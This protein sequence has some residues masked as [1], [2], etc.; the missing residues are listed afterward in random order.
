MQS[1]LEKEVSGF[2]FH[3]TLEQNTSGPFEIFHGKG[4]QIYLRTAT[5]FADGETLLLLS[6]FFFLLV[7]HSLNGHFQ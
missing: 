1:I 4:D 3:S 7:N 5:N 2:S 6:H